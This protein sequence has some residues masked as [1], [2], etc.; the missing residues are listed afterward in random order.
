MENHMNDIEWIERYLDRSL[1]PD[2]IRDLEKRMAEEPDLKSKYQ[3][4][5][6][7]IQGIRYSHL[8]EKLEQLKTLENS[9]PAIE[10]RAAAQKQIFIRKYWKPLAL[11]ASILLAAFSY[12]F[13]YDPAPATDR[14]FATY[15]E[16]F[17]SPGPGLTR[18]QNDTPELTWRQKGYQ[19]YDNGRYQ[20]AIAFF[21]KALQEKNDPIVDLCMGNAYLKLEQYEKAEAVFESMLKDHDDLVTQA[22]WYLALTYVKQNKLERAKSTLW[23]ISKSSTYGEKA[24][25]LLKELD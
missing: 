24:M 25:K 15:F 12:L 2:E 11:A 19:A 7:L 5:L 22:N 20:E 10:A 6:Q 13:L 18:G 3:E 14:L 8:R 21:D 23:G 1:T 16:P 17:D 4:H 9:L